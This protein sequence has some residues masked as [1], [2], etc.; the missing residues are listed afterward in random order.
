MGKKQRETFSQ[1]LSL[2]SLSVYRKLLAW[3]VLLFIWASHLLI[4][5]ACAFSM[6]ADFPLVF[7]GTT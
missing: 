4:D 2:E 1:T 5:G 6:L 7:K 3:I